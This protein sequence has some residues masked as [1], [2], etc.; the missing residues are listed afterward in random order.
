MNIQFTRATRALVALKI[1]MMGPSGSGKTTAALE[2][3]RGLVGPTGKIAVLDTENGSASLYSD[4]TEFDALN[5]T[6]PYGVEKFLAA[7][8]AAVEGG[9]QALVIDSASHEWIQILQD[10]ESLDARGGNSYANWA[11]FTKKHEAFL[12]AIRNAPIHLICCLRGKEKHE[13]T[14]QKKV[15]KLG[16]GSQMRDGFEFEMTTVF[17][18]SMDHNAKATKDRT[19]IFEGRLEPITRKTGQE[20]AAWLKGG[21]VLTPQA[22]ASSPQVEQA[23]GPD[24]PRAAGLAQPAETIGEMAANVAQAIKEA[25]AEIS[26]EASD[27]V[28]G[29]TPAPKTINIDQFTKIVDACSAHQVNIPDLTAYCQAKGRL[30]GEGLRSLLAEFYTPLL[31]SLKS[32]TRRAQLIKD[33]TPSKETAA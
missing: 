14:D 5:M 27:F 3:T 9:Y 30:A 32:T 17:D 26:Q 1:G 24:S 11:Q 10:K 13:I 23:K 6:A 25:P 31:T 12:T 8:D 33:I 22:A 18:L 20:L 16:M 7:I 28:D 19:R 15:V 2:L 21:A 29:L 4:L